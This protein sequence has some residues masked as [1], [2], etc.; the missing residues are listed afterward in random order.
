MQRDK[1]RRLP[2]LLR[3]CW[4][5]LNTAFQKRLLPFG[6]TPDQYTALRWIY[7]RDSKE[8]NQVTLAAL[9][10]TD[11]NNISSLLSRMVKSGLVERM[12]SS[13]DHR[14]KY[15]KLTPAG[16]KKFKATRPVALSL[17]KEVLTGLNSADKETFLPLL[18][19]L[20]S[21]LHHST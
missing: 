17:E 11:A 3:S 9:M 20:S 13:S 2:P 7:E 4:I 1:I 15:L 18:N 8:T 16:L 12:V 10:F 14:M 6:I 19:R 5:K 21:Y